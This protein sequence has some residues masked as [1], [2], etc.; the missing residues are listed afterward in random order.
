MGDNKKVKKTE[1]MP[2][3]A[4]E[5]RLKNLANFVE[6]INCEICGG[7]YTPENM[8]HHNRSVKHRKELAKRE[9]YEKIKTTYTELLIE[10]MRLKAENDVL[11]QNI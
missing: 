8:S 7:R 6:K 10:Y 9:E 5:Y 4:R 1:H 2:E 11:K 3:Y